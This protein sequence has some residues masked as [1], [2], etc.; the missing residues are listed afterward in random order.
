MCY[1][2]DPVSFELGD[3]YIKHF[4]FGRYIVGCKVR[5]FVLRRRV[6]PIRTF[7]A[8]KKSHQYEIRCYAH[9]LKGMNNLVV[10]SYV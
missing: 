3:N 4:H 1:T 2:P 5:N 8:Y 10:F 9:V 6:A 7:C